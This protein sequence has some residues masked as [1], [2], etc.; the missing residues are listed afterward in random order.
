MK[1]VTKKRE[2]TQKVDKKQLKTQQF[3]QLVSLGQRCSKLWKTPE[4]VAYADVVLG[5]NRITCRIE[6]QQF[7]DW[8]QQKYYSETG[9]DCGHK[10]ISSAIST[11]STV[12]Q[13]NGVERAFVNRVAEDN[14]YYYLDLGTTPDS[15]VRYSANGWEIVYISPINFSKSVA[16]L[17]L[18]TPSSGIETS[19]ALK[20]FYELIGVT[21]K[22]QNKVTDFLIKC[23]IPSDREPVITFWS[24]CGTSSSR[25]AEALKRMID[26]CTI[27]Q[28]YKFP[29]H[30][31]LVEQA[32]ISRVILYEHF[33]C[34]DIS[35][36][37]VDD[38]I[39]ISNGKGFAAGISRPQISAY[40][41]SVKR[42]IP[43]D[44]ISVNS[45]K[46]GLFESEFDYWAEFSIIHPE[47]LGALLD[48]V[49]DRLAA[50]AG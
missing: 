12:T 28:L 37:D 46:G 35:S 15:F 39:D 17:T 5:G 23:L 31:K 1:S 14:G 4:G 9:S 22:H 3:N 33:N 20:Y 2:N 6:S 38:I 49:C 29:S 36:D 42:W 10:L 18:P 7:S 47:V 13:I 11:L 19:G 16:C 30:A 26:P 21:E 40:T 44:C 43:N 24:D 50:T 25:A 41:E 45:V 34:Q 48:A 8:L 27:N 32:E